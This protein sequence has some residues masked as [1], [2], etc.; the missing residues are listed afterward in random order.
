MAKAQYYR[1]HFNTEPKLTKLYRPR[2]TGSSSCKPKNDFFYSSTCQEFVFH[3]VISF[4]RCLLFGGD[5]HLDA[6]QDFD[7]TH[8]TVAAGH[9]CPDAFGRFTVDTCVRLEIWT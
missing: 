5:A 2:S 7:V 8:D 1:L 3:H 6:C 9:A 4:A